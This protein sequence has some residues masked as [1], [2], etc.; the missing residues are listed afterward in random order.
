VL[1][2]EDVEVRYDELHCTSGELKV[3]R[4]ERVCAVVS[5]GSQAGTP[6]DGSHAV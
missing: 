4:A 5:A 6:V 1:C 2:A 3:G